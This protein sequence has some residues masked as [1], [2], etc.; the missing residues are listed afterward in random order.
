MASA[1]NPWR[2]AEPASG[3]NPFPTP[4]IHFDF[5]HHVIIVSKPL[6]SAL[7]LDGERCPSG[8][9]W[10][11]FGMMP[12]VLRARLLAPVCLSGIVRALAV[13]RGG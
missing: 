2:H 8:G 12:W 9:T 13:G 7:F 6:Q 11:G 4:G 3:P 5:Y 1:Q 10:R